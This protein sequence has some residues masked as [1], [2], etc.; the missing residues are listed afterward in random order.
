MESFKCDLEISALCQARKIPETSAD[1]VEQL[2]ADYDFFLSMMIDQHAPRP[3][4]ACEV[5]SLGS[6]VYSWDQCC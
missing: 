6:L 1:D 2:A 4:Q 5:T 3:F